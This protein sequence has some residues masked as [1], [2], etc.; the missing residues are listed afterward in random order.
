MQKNL[1]EL[2]LKNKE[3]QKNY[4]LKEQNENNLNKEIS[5]IKNKNELLN[6]EM[7]NIKND[8]LLMKLAIN[9]D[10]GVLK[11]LHRMGLLSN[12]NINNNY[13]QI[14]PKTNQFISNNNNNL[15]IDEESDKKLQEFYDIIINISSVKDIAKG[16]E[17]KMTQEGEKNFLKY[18]DKELLKIGVIGNSNKGKSFILSKISKFNLPSGTSI[19]TEGLSIK[20]PEKKLF[21]N[22]NIV[23]LDSAGLET[24]VL[25]EDSTDK[26]IENQFSDEEESDEEGNRNKEKKEEIKDDNNKK[27]ENQANKELNNKEENKINENNLNYGNANQK[28]KEEE[29]K[30]EEGEIKEEI[31]EK[32]NNIIFKEKSRE[33]LIT[34]LFLQNYII[35]NSDILI[36]VVGILSYS[37]QKLLNRIKTDIQK[38]KINKTLFIIHNLKSYITKNQVKNYI[39]NTLMKSATFDLKK[40][41]NTSI[42]IDTKKGIYFFEK[43][44]SPKIFHLIYANEDSEAGKYYNNFSLDFIKRAFQEITDLSSFNVIRSI[45]ER[46]IEL[47]TEIIEKSNE[48]QKVFQIEDLINDDESI[49]NKIIKLKNPQKIILKRCLIDELGFSNLRG[50]G[51]EPNFNYY[52]KGDN[53]IVRVEAPGNST[54]SSKFDYSGEYTIIRLSGHKNID[55]EPE[56]KSD[57]I[58]TSREFGDF[59]LDIPLKTE[60]YNVKNSE[61]KIE[62][63]KGVIILAYELEKKAETYNYKGNEEDD[64]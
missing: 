45:K 41:H 49:K 61:P 27:N 14:D 42:E 28:K 19:K 32:S 23:L 47:S 46:F 33:K 35:K 12:I 22:R 62:S 6:N 38:L 13:I 5:T 37:E 56:N 63:K 64:I 53:I 52:R 43:N 40:G 34:E 60:D 9:K 26:N 18:K 39:K 30:C 16:W 2:I 7:D 17:I 20:Y 48:N 4:S 44:S 25:K 15:L 57:N 21:K 1:D 58:H 11:E 29:K 31:E 59:N 24:P 51:F 54:I 50:N 8:N 55:K 36:L 3:I 10:V